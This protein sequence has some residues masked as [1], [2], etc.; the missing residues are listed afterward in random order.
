[1]ADST[2]NGETKSNKKKS[3]GKS[4]LIPVST[5]ILFFVAVF[6]AVGA[7][8]VI[9]NGIIAESLEYRERG[10]S[11]L[12]SR[13]RGS[14]I[15]EETGY[16]DYT[17]M[18]ES[19]AKL[20]STH[21][22]W[23]NVKKDP[24]QTGLAF[25]AT[26]DEGK[27]MVYNVDPENL[28]GEGYSFSDF[29]Y[30]WVDSVNTGFY[31]LIN[32]PGKVVDLS[33]YYILVHDDTGNLA[34]RLI[35]NCYEAK[36][37]I[38]KDAVVTGTLLAPGANV[39]YGNTIVYG[40]VYAKV[41]TGSR[42]YYKQISFGGYSEILQES[43][44]ALFTNV[45]MRSVTLGWLKKHIPAEYAGYPEDYVPNTADLARITDLNL[46]GQFIADMQDD[47]KYLVNLESLSLR[48]T[49]LRQ[50]DV[51]HLSRLKTLD[52]S[53]TEISDVKLPDSGSLETLIADNSALRTL[54]VSRLLNARR[55]SLKNVKL[56][57]VPDYSKLAHAE[58]INLS[59]AGIGLQ[60]LQ[61][62]E[63][64]TA[65]K[66]LNISGNKSITELDLG[67]FETVEVLNVSECALAAISVGS[68]TALKEIDISYNPLK[69]AD[70][71]AA[72]SL[73]RVSAYGDFETVKVAGE[74]V[75]VSKLPSTK[76]VFQ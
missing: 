4:R 15:T 71:S 21:T 16:G 60:E 12:E 44:K 63:K 20:S 65:L 46:D 61:L 18:S 28:C 10:V 5:I 27:R 59:G 43:S 64:L 48:N 74:H 55:L 39:E 42:A 75:L 7:V 76:V 6:A 47:L 56:G 26:V 37:V 11:V 41:S 13:N 45:I 38:L 69:N 17:K 29:N 73:L 57:I 8:A 33:G 54:D 52:V 2:R 24:T 1:M 3:G 50:V 9:A 58:D 40:G 51:S 53:D 31:C 34:S 72:K 30:L 62:L 14:A 49:K 22:E 25:I 70:L 32:I 23:T 36:A 66:T 19:L 67:I 68:D 35:L